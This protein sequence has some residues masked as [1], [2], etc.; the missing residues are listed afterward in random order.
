MLFPGI[1]SSI[2]SYSKK[3]VEGYF[4]KHGKLQEWIG[5]IGIP[6]NIIKTSRS[7]F[8]F[9]HGD[10]VPTVEHGLLPEYN[11]TIQNLK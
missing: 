4:G 5:K 2:D 11:A 1:F 3:S 10:V 6:K 7:T 8:R 9:V